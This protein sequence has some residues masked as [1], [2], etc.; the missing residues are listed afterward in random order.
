MNKTAS[1]TVS[2]PCS[3]SHDLL[4]LRIRS[5]IADKEM[6]T[7]TANL[8]IARAGEWGQDYQ[9]WHGQ[10]DKEIEELFSKANDQIQPANQK[11]N[12]S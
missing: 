12:E 7:A 8:D 11:E 6:V 9:A 1:K 5:L 10:I 4:A 2:S 3:P